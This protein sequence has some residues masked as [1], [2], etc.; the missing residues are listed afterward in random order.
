M[1]AKV[2]GTRMILR[3]RFKI[4]SFLKKR[5][6]RECIFMV[7][8]ACLFILLRMTTFVQTRLYTSLLPSTIEHRFD[9]V[10]SVALQERFIQ[11]SNDQRA[12][13]ND[14]FTPERFIESLKKLFPYLSA[15]EWEYISCDSVRIKVSG[16]YPRV[17]VNDYE[18]ILH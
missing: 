8:V 14:H 4:S 13:L 12:L 18:V 5:S 2:E 10:Y 1:K 6:Q 15:F 9:S 17:V 7:G 3:N 11:A 16:P